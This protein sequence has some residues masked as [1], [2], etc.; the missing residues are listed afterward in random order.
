VKDY[1]CNVNR[2]VW[3]LR[4]PMV[5]WQYRTTCNKLIGKTTFR[6]LY[7]QETIMPIEYIVLGL[8]IAVVIDMVDLDIMKE[9][10]FSILS[11][12]EDRFIARFR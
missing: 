11:L 9:R 8:R 10:M 5:L 3:D 6:L 4:I 1:K 7:G 12:E 2:D